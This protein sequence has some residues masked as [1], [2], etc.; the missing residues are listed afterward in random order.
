MPKLLFSKMRIYE[1]KDLIPSGRKPRKLNGLLSRKG[2]KNNI[3]CILV[4]KIA[5]NSPCDDYRSKVQCGNTASL[6]ELL[7]NRYYLV[8]FREFLQSEFSEENIDFWLACRDYRDFTPPACRFLRA[9]E[10]YQEFLHPTAVKEVNVDQCTRDKVKRSMAEASPWCFD[11]AAA[12]VF[13]LMESDSW[14]RFLHSS[15]CGRLRAGG[16]TV[17]HLTSSSKCQ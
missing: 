16:P 8:T 13:R 7:K 9:T 10:I 17:P 5:E 2:Q 14:P 12:H 1:F 6:G 4:R 3:R 11:E 15:A